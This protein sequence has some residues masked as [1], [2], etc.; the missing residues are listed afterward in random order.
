VTHSPAAG[1]LDL[2]TT[3]RSAT[4]PAAMRSEIRITEI[5][6]RIDDLQQSQLESWHPAASG[7]QLIGAQ[8]RAALSEATAQR[9]LAASIEALLRAAMAH[10]RSAVQH[11]RAAAAGAAPW[12]TTASGQHTTGNCNRSPAASRNSPIASLQLRR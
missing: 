6:A 7:E 3:G 9:A 11:E 4:T 12:N 2:W 1:M 8:H 5:R 10:D